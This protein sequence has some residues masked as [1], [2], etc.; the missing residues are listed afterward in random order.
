MDDEKDYKESG[1][2]IVKDI[3]RATRKHYSSEEKIRIV[4][5]G[6]RGE[7]SNAELCRCAILGPDNCT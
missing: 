6:L 2:K 4:Q 1:E 7:D 3:K 5:D